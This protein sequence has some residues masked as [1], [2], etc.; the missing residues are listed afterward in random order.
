[1]FSKL[2]L[3]FGVIYNG[4]ICSDEIW[5]W[6]HSRSVDHVVSPPNTPNIPA[7]RCRCTLTDPGSGNDAPEVKMS[8]RVSAVLGT[9]SIPNPLDAS[10]AREAMNY[11]L[12]AGYDEID[13]AIL[14]QDGKTEMTLGEERSLGYLPGLIVT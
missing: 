10:N 12:A 2:A 13:T 8:R 6:L 5:G 3:G 4:A 14:Y 1:M 11:F 9:M 7:F